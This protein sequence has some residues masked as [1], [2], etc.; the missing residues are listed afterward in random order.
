MDDIEIFEVDGGGFGYRVQLVVQYWHP[1]KEG[2]VP[3]TR[4]EAEECAAV[5]AARMAG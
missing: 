4:E 1:D 3:M 5:V 2:F